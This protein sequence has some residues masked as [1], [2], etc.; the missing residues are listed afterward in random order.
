VTA[1]AT[2][3]GAVAV[4]VAVNGQTS[5][6]A[7]NFTFLDPP[8]AAN[9]P[10][11]VVAYNSA[12][13]AIDLAPSITGGAHTSIAIG[14]APAHGTTAIAGDVVTY[15][16]T[17]GYF[18]A[19]SFTYTA[20]GPGGTS[21][22]ATVTLTVS[23]PAAPVVA[24][25]N[26]TVPYNSSGTTIDLT[27]SI[28][29]VSSS[30]A[31]GTAPAHGTTSIAGNVVTYTPTAGYFGADSFTVTATGPGG[32]SAPA[33][34]TIT[35]A[36]PAAPVV[37]NRSAAVPYNSTGTAIDLTASITGVSSSIA[38]GTAPA[39]GTTSIAGEVVTYT[40]TAG[41]FGADSFTYTATGPGGVS[42]TATVTL[43][44]AVPPAPI[45]ANNASAVAYN[46]AG[47]AIDLTASITGVRTSIAIGTAPAHGTTSVAGEVVTYTPT[48]GYFGAD[49]FTYTAT[50]PGGTSTPATVT[51]TVATPAAPVVANANA[52]VPYN[53]TGTAI[54]LTASITGVSSS[55]AIGTAP[56]HGT[57]SIA[58]NVV[59]YTPTAGYFGADS[60]TVTATGPGGTSTPAT[61][62]LTVANP[63]AP[64]VANRSAAV[65]YN[66]S[67]T[68]IDLTAS[69]TGVSSSIAIGT[70]PAHGTTSIAGNVVTYTPTAGYFGAD[71]FTV[72]ATGPG[73]ASA[74]ATVTI[75]VATPAAPV[76]ANRSA[77]VAYNSSGTAIDLTASI[78]GVSSSIAIGTAPAH[79]TTSIAGNVVTYT[80]TAGYFGA[81]S[82]TVTATGPGGTSA[83]ATVTITVATPA[84][85]VVANRSAAVPYNS[86][87]TTIDLTASITGVS[88]SIAIGTAPAHGT[89]SIAGNVVTYTPT[90]GYFGADSF[91]F[92]ATGPGGTSTPATVSLTVAT[93]AAPV[94]ANRS[95][96]VAY[97]STGTAIDLG[98]SITGVRTSIA[99][100][101]APAHG[102]TSIA[103]EI[104]TYTPTAGY[105]G[106]D[107]FNYTATGPGG[108]SNTATVTL[109]VA[110]PPA[111]VAVNRSAAVAYNSTGTAIDLTSSI[112]GVRTSIAIG[113]APA[114]GTTSVA[115][116]VV[117]YTPTTG[118]FGTDSF[119][120]TATG[121]GGVSNTATVTLTVAVPPA[122]VVANNAAPVPY[123]STGTAIDLTSSVTGVRTSIS[124][125]TAPA[126]GT[127]S[128]AGEVVTYTP[129]AGYY[130]TDSFT[131]TATGPGG[132]SNT[133]TVTLTIAVPPAPV[134]TN[135][136]A[137]V[138]YNSTGTAI[139]LGT[140]ITG[141]R[142]SIAIGTAPAHGTTSI[143]GEVVTYTPTTGYYGVDSFT[144]TA[145]GPG[146]V[147][148]TATVTLTVA[149]PPAP[150]VANNAAA[151]PYNSTGTA[152][153]LTSS[154]TGV[155]TG[156]AIGTTPAHG[157]TSITGEVVTYTP[158]TGY[159][160]ADSF[161]YTAT[162]PGGVSNTA[163]VTLTVA[164]PPA[165]VVANNAAAVS[166]NST[167]TAIDLGTSI[168]GVRTSIGIGTAP[169][170]GTTS[171]A[172]EVVTYTPTTGYFGTDSFTYTATG[173][174]GVSNTATVTLT[175]AVPPAPVAANR[176]AAV[177]Y[178]STG[179]AIDLTSSV[180]GVRTSISIGTAPAHGTTSIA[181]EVVTY[182]PT[183]GYFGADSFTYTA[184]GPGGISNTATVTLT[185]AVPPAPVAVNRSAAVAYNSTG[186]AID[187]GTSITGV[188]TSI[189]VGT[190]P[191]HGTTS[192]AGEV[193]TYTPTTGY[194][195][196]DS[197]TYT[198]TG[199]GG[200]SNVAT[201]T[202][203]VATP[204]AP[205]AANRS[206][207]AVP[208]NS[209]GTAIDLT[210][211]VTG[212]YTSI[213]VATA[214]AH[215][216]TAIAGS[217]VTY[218]PT[219]GYFGTDSFT[220]T[221]TGPGG[222]SNTATV[223]LTVATPAAPVA[224]NRAAPV[225]YNSAGTAI[226]LT[227]SITGVSSSIAIGTA[228]AHGSASVAGNI[229]T[230][231]PTPGYY[232][233]DSFT[234]TATGPG[235]VSNTATV[236]L[237]VATP[238]APVAANRAAPVAY[239]SAGTAIDL[240]ASITGVSSSIAI[241]TA[242]A[243][244]TTSIA[245]N[246]VTYTPTTGYF[247]ADSFTYT[248]TGPGGV[249]NVATVTLTV[250]TPAAPVAANRS[251]VAVPF[252]STGTT[253]D[254]TSSVTGV[255]TSITVATAPAHGITAIAGSVVTYTPTT[256][257]YGVDSFTYTATGPG[258][259]SN[260]ATVT[261]TVATPAAPVAANR[262]AP[263]A[264]NSAGTA[265][266][267]TAS[268]TGVSSSIAIGTAPAHGTASVAGNIVTYIP[269]T[270]YFGADSFTYTATGPGGVSNVAT[271]TLT[272]ATPPPPAAL[273]G[274]GAVAG[275]SSINAN[276]SVDIDLSGLVT[277]EYDSIS[278]ENQPAHGTVTL[279]V[280]GN[281]PSGGRQAALAIGRT[282]ATYRPATGFVGVDTFTFYATGPGGRSAAAAVQVTVV[283]SVPVALPKTAATGDGQTVSVELTTGATE[284]PFTGAAVVSIAPANSAT[285][286]IVDSGTGVARTFRLEVTPNA[287][288]SG[289]VTVGYTLTNAYGTSAPAIVTVAVTARPN[290][291]ADPNVV[292][293]SDAQAETT[294]RFARS[295]VSNFMRRTEQLH[296]GGGRSATMGVTLNSRDGHGFVRQ[297]PAFDAYALEITER[298]RPLAE[299]PMMA[300]AANMRDPR[301]SRADML[302][303][304]SM[305][306][307]TTAVSGTTRR[308]GGVAALDR[309]VLSEDSE[310]EGSGERRIGTIAIWSGGAIDIGTRD[311]TTRSTK[312]TA[313]TSGLS[314]GAD[315]K[316][317][318][319]VIVG[320]GG[321]YGNDVSHI[322][323]SA[324]RV[325]GTS[326]LFAAYASVSPGDAAFIDGMVGFGDL[327]FSTRRAV[328]TLNVNALGS[329]DG[330]YT[331]G[332][333]AAG[334]DKQSAALRWSVY[335]RGEFM[336]AK[337]GAYAET[338]AG[339]MNLRFDE[340]DVRSL[341]GTLGARIEFTGDA[342][343]AKVTPRVRAEWNHEFADADAQLLDYADIPGVAL[344]SLAT[345]GWSRDQLQL[346]AGARF[347]FQRRWSFD[348]EAGFRGGSS[349]KAGT[350]RV[351]ISKEF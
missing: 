323:G 261:L 3:S 189:A 59:T 328:T 170:H 204:A 156:I 262:A 24:N 253:I 42:N 130:G 90:A 237:T 207:V 88:S 38:I 54:D 150:V 34:V 174:G 216:I 265:I 14:T 182:T 243:H 351:Q 294:R 179:T 315:F 63:A 247:G 5:I 21:A 86:T 195:G 92:T 187:L 329:R 67:G 314:A 47:T 278:I 117:T 231:I 296:G 8:I 148:N 245:G 95:A 26:A 166:Y 18:G 192:I 55:I 299:D 233:A 82:F 240:T 123:N 145:T 53:S 116:E 197:F 122:P 316:L 36:T 154:I 65:A 100:G 215:G 72:T 264:Y 246:V 89:T 173:P 58:G 35:V 249:S 292:G 206:G 164:V 279:R 1:P 49:S 151:V 28:T 347:A 330:N 229:V 336:N 7:V 201:V 337:L 160:G 349:E 309:P 81:D 68:A 225:A 270:G 241:G 258:G 124:I 203:T 251:G 33:T 91:T 266:D 288:F 272:V 142:T 10:G 304:G 134:A 112:T 152:I 239:N 274:T 94:V 121:P 209:T 335:G 56:A 20:T 271:V 60:F 321:G 281:A 149:V 188:R 120:Y 350:L 221:A 165:P 141:V 226:D 302:G 331:V 248:A 232:G 180:T 143:A 98:T 303:S 157:M 317:S 23:T 199:P 15:T 128:I 83:P 43:T 113:T 326:S 319:G 177:V 313:T 19:D 291:T 282:V 332:A 273:P 41:Y 276:S 106:A 311:A 161:T 61:V 39:H 138:A 306:G 6:G 183:A 252:N 341:T 238:A 4:T 255:Y 300:Q 110:V 318:D 211:S 325:R 131:Y 310:G 37:A 108:V 190:A 305:T 327:S 210:S 168:T 324:A 57:T 289:N 290:P 74:P 40:P 114:H 16:P 340:R 200:V 217:V 297:S 345:Q 29:G 178:N 93:P 338:G 263:V 75:T 153:D 242:P 87:G 223:T 85:P 202:L 25:A 133:A 97:N 176:S 275:S 66:S 48:T 162:G 259:V 301:A 333:L 99:I 13:T 295:Q 348:I 78:T 343:F 344:F 159:F 167:G 70:A 163:T 224:A 62:T 228:P 115:G 254:L 96:A 308:N 137:A 194:F 320:L 118:Y 346:T 169:A 2:G 17:A 250:A 196:T 71:S 334:I 277:G 172:G 227:A 198:A 11:V 105:F 285:T 135:R 27:A 12:G 45:V 9:K 44:V 107:S 80:P 342:G 102:T 219:A 307:I 126:H 293:V 280:L 136:S 132:V 234:Y 32:A 51:L 104:V 139:D 30:I 109:T 50:G 284:G 267:L 144:Y 84:A 214:P 339:R 101:T 46:S 235:G 64:V 268:I 158:T 191:A 260:T 103:G 208:F 287:R 79:G 22:P 186:T 185:V 111:P 155:R 52:T 175:V 213:A 146:G 256:G 119:T 77:A 129:T 257:Y 73:G 244:G 212:V 322:G 181:G 127:T 205:V 222:V 286:R 283:G 298:M 171:I 76:V 220:Y 193:V 69:I 147:S 140:S 184:T 125:G 269:T 230:Y 218:T 312:I 236:T 31:I